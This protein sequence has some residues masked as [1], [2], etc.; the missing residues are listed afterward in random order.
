MLVRSVHSWFL[1]TGWWDWQYDKYRTS[2]LVYLKQLQRNLLLFEEPTFV[3]YFPGKDYFSFPYTSLKLF[4]NL[5][6]LTFMKNSN[7]IMLW[8]Q[9]FSSCFPPAAVWHSVVLYHRCAFEL[10]SSFSVRY[11]KRL[12]LRH[13]L[14]YT[15]W[16]HVLLQGQNT[17][18]W[19]HNTYIISELKI[20]AVWQYRSLLCRTTRSQSGLFGCE[21]WWHAVKNNQIET[22][23]PLTD[24]LIL[25]CNHME[26]STLN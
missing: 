2:Q 11:P 8:K 25:L 19:A 6:V 20:A 12:G 15:R 5:K 16:W 18:S 1:V 17:S 24:G 14:L 22:A 4:F 26:A 9:L 23:T 10:F 3:A 13:G 21:T 7:L